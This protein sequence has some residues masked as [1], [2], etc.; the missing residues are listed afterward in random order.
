[1]TLDLCSYTQLGDKNECVE[2]MNNVVTN[3]KGKLTQEGLS[4]YSLEKR[5]RLRPN[6]IHNIL[7]GRSK[8][9][10]INII[11]AIAKALNCTVS[12]LI[13]EQP[14]ILSHLQIDDEKFDFDIVENRELYI[15]CLS[16]FSSLLNKQK[17]WLS[18][19]QILDYV[20]EL[21]LYSF[22]KSATKKVDTHF[23]QWLVD[24]N[25]K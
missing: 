2:H 16:Y 22:K 21:Y 4:A 8:K 3:I 18:K 7:S 23:A 25:L 14:K 15:K 11:Q 6:A 10:S 5:A 1:M 9:P 24:K 13:G 17:L 19:T 12:E 20:D